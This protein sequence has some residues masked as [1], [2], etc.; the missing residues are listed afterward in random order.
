MSIKILITG[1]TGFV[2]RHLVPKILNRDIEIL[3][4]TR[5]LSKS[6]KLFGDNT[7]KIE[8]SDPLF[9]ERIIEFKPEIVI[10]IASY[11]T[12]SDQWQYVQKLIYTNLFFKNV[13]N[14]IR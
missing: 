4:V 14:G 9:N 1:S 6:T 12:A 3:E 11:L 13:R 8:I 5:S 2:G 7:L 10:H